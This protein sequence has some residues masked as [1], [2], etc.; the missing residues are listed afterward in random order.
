MTIWRCTLVERE[1]T[2]K[3]EGMSYMVV[4]RRSRRRDVV[5]LWSSGPLALVSLERA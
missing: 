2:P 3:R 5:R 1:P 4:L